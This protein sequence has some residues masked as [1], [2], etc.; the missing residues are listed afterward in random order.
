MSYVVTIMLT[1]DRFLAIRYCLEYYRIVTNRRIM[2][3]VLISFSVIGPILI[4]LTRW[5]TIQTNMILMISSGVLI[6]D[7][8]FR[9]LTIVIVL[10]VGHSINRIRKKTILALLCHHTSNLQQPPGHALAERLV[11][12]RQQEMVSRLRALKQS[13]RDV[14]VLNTWTVI[15]LT[16]RVLTGFFIVYYN[17]NLRVVDIVFRYLYLISNPVIYLVTQTEL[18]QCVVSSLRCV[19]KQNKVG[20]QQFQTPQTFGKGIEKNVI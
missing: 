2:L 3:A 16:P 19:K 6:A 7:L 18:R 15:F 17:A 12:G 20:S 9:C 14:T 8:S 13:I 4:A 5:T 1:W 11:F 10:S